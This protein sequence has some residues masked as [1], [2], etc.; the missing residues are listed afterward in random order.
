MAKIDNLNLLKYVG[1]MAKAGT[2]P[3]NV[4]QQKTYKTT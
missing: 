1:H 2:G 3:M 4:D